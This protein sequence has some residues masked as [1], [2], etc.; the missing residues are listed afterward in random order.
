MSVGPWR[1]LGAALPN[2]IEGLNRE[3]VA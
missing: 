3:V 2:E 1:M